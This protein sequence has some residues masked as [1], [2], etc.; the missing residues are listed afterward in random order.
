[1]VDKGRRNHGYD[2]L[3]R[4][5]LSRDQRADGMADDAEAA[6]KIQPGFERRY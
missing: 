6:A 5:N 4:R 1:M 2:R 3:L